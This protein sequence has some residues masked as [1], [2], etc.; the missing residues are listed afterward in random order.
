MTRFLLL[1]LPLH[2]L[3]ASSICP[4]SPASV[5]AKCELTVTF[6]EPCNEVMDEMQA[7][8]KSNKWVD[9]HNQG[10][11]TLGSGPAS[12]T[13]LEVSRTTGDNRYTDK[14]AIEFEASSSSGGC[15]IQA[16]STSQVTSVL[17]YSTNFCNLRNLYCNSSDNCAAIHHE[18]TYTEGYDDCWQRTADKCNTN[19]KSDL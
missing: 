18:L 8:I 19:K 9:P 10:T 12:D 17:D 5:H 13:R 14:M 3:A 7:R 16:C 15:T 11:Y 4:A 2:A 1:L 6:E